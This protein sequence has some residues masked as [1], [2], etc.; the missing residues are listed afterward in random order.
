M[1]DLSQQN[2]SNAEDQKPADLTQ[3]TEQA[4]DYGKILKSNLLPGL[5]ALSS[6]SQAAAAGLK[7]MASAGAQAAGALA[8]D[9]ASFYNL[10]P[11]DTFAQIQ[12]AISG[13]PGALSQLGVDMS[14][15]SLEAFA[16]SQGL[17]TAY[18]DMSQM[19]QATLRY[20]YLMSASAQ[21]Q[22]SFANSQDSLA[23]QMNLARLQTESLSGA[24]GQQLMPMAVQG[25]KGINLM[26]GAL[27]QGFQ[28]GGV[29]GMLDA[30]AQ[31]A[32]QISAGL[33]QA[34]PGLAASAGQLLS[35][36][37]L[38]LAQNLP[39]LLTSVGQVLS[40][41]ATT[42]GPQLLQ[43]GSLLLNQL[44]T[45][46]ATGLPLL[47]A[48]AL[49][50]LAQF[51]GSL[52]M[53]A[54]QL[55]NAGLSLISSLVQGL[56]ASL[57]TLITYVPIIITNIANIINQNMPKILATGIL[58]ISQLCLG[59]LQ[60][61]PTLIANAG[62]I[63]LAILSVLAAFNWLSLGSRLLNGIING[64]KSVGGNLPQTI[65]DLLDQAIQ[66]IRSINWAEMGQNIIQGIVNGLKAMP[67]L[68]V[69]TLL[70]IMG[71]AVDAV[72][73]FFGIGSPSKL[74][75]DE[76]GRWLP[77]GAALGIAG[78]TDQAADA[79]GGMA[80]RMLARA[81]AVLNTADSRLFDA[82]QADPAGGNSMVRASFQGQYTTTIE[83]DGR[84]V[85][86]VVAPYVDQYLD[87]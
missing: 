14:Q 67:G 34:A 85:G 9:F 79:M 2:L 35:D 29:S 75:R 37:F 39:S 31:A 3:Q 36:L 19:E 42:L 8:G 20:N 41:A 80:Q 51:S 16:L 68:V 7:T 27:N 13:D 64:I 74:M 82:R 32:Q 62:S 44:T 40:A 83:M 22:G 24:I 61:I 50:M 87:S 66:H 10:D 43:T 49:P 28:Q 56:I 45:G 1:A 77:A 38:G 86:K 84:T 57:P 47:L 5:K 30:A 60:N 4:K 71:S 15:A 25:A 59:I 69:D 52:C 72:K 46:L 58:L 63:V 48:Q 53:G 33:V 26:L 55:V 81:H 23:S 78:G 17:S 18:G 11:A 12:A 76:V 73:S 54:G 6:M 70:N 65:K 21:A